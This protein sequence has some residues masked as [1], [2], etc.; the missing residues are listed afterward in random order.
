[1][2]KR[3][4]EN[5]SEKK[6]NPKKVVKQRQ[7]KDRPN[8]YELNTSHSTICPTAPA[9]EESAGGGG[10]FMLFRTRQTRGPHAH[11]RDPSNV[12][13]TELGSSSKQQNV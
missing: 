13:C 4:R 3:E 8:S 5:E 12:L 10:D 9:R 6:G 2:R 7:E 11:Q 1:M